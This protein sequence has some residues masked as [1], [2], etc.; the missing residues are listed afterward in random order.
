MYFLACIFL[1]LSLDSIGVLPPPRRRRVFGH[2]LFLAACQFFSRILSPYLFTFAPHTHTHAN[3]RSTRPV[4]EVAVSNHF[5]C[6]IY[7]PIVS[8]SRGMYFSLKRVCYIKTKYCAHW[9]WGCRSVEGAPFIAEQTYS[10]DRFLE[11]R[12]LSP[13]CC[14]M[15]LSNLS[16]S[17]VIGGVLEEYHSLQ[18]LYGKVRKIK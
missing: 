2:H 15:L 18:E 14:I 9:G 6:I 10:K 13:V 12:V 16:P 4:Q 7:C 1:C 3:T 17:R 8:H 5:S 11:R